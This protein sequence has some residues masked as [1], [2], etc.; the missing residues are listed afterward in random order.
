[1]PQHR[2]KTAYHLAIPSKQDNRIV[3]LCF[4][5]DGWQAVG[6]HR[7]MCTICDAVHVLKITVVE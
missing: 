5:A 7:Q 3:I 2:L 1:M 4:A 6:S